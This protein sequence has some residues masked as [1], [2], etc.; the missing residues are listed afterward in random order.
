MNHAEKQRLTREFWEL[1]DEFDRDHL[2]PHMTMK[3]FE[4]LQKLMEQLG[5]K[6][7]LKPEVEEAKQLRDNFEIMREDLMTSEHEPWKFPK[8]YLL[9][10]NYLRTV[11]TW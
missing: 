3:Q 10:L 2:Y 6:K 5:L 7:T 4:R 1:F 11:W 8:E 9:D